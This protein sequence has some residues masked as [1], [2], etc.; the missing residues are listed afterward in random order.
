MHELEFN[1]EKD[2]VLQYCQ[3]KSALT[4]Y[5]SGDVNIVKELETAVVGT[6]ICRA[7]QCPINGTVA[8]L[9]SEQ[10]VRLCAQNN[11]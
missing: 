11:I 4:E 3:G 2:R 10:L 1:A 7:P 8:E 5:Y 9:S 6:G